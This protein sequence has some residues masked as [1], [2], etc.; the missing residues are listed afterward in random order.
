MICVS[1]CRSVDDGT[2]PSAFMPP[3]VSRLSFEE[4]SGAPEVLELGNLGR[5]QN[6]LA[7]KKSEARPLR[8]DPEWEQNEV[9]ASLELDSRGCLDTGAEPQHP[10]SGSTLNAFERGSKKFLFASR[11]I[12]MYVCVRMWRRL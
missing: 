9:S 2:D 12:F 1:N 6:K 10:G 3:A 8:Q 5:W 4:A 11:Y 7:E